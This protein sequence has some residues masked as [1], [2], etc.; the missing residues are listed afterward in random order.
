MLNKNLPPAILIDDG[1]G[2]D[3]LMEDLAG[4]QEIAV[5]TEADSFFAYREKVCLIQITVED[6][7][8][9]VDPLA[10]VDLKPLGDILADPSKVKIFHDG[11]Y[12]VLIMKRDYGFSFSN[13]FDTRVAA[14]TLGSETP[15]LASVLNEHFGVE[16]DKS[17]QRSNWGERPLSDRQLDYARLDTRFLIPLMHKQ[18]KALREKER[19]MVLEGECLRLEGLEPTDI[20]FKPDEW[21]KI[22]GARTLDPTGRAILK[23]LFALRDELASAVN[24]PLFRVINNQTLL[25]IVA[26]RPKNSGALGEV[27]GFS[28]R[29]VRKY[30]E[31]VLDAVQRGLDAEPIKRLPKLPPKDGTGGFDDEQVELHER[32]KTWRRSAASKEGFDASLLLNRHAL[33]K[34]VQSLPASREEVAAIEGIWPWQS[35]R[36]ADA[37]IEVLDRF[38]KD[39]A[40]GLDLSKRRRRGR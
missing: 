9:I 28:P 37:L 39:L 30:G 25:G 1:A 3:R 24:S 26:A 29:Q 32:L 11:E 34:I 27:H 21:V 14:A 33:I 7:D 16:L 20:E 35:E 40:N 18:Q 4:Q 8:Y 22:K 36:Y 6:R 17:M 19:M 2:L 12:D 10:D 13:L 38:K 15:G 5:D 23:E 31:R